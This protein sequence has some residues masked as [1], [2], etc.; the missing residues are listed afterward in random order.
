MVSG[1]TSRRRSCAARKGI[2]KYSAFLAIIHQ[3]PV[4][5]Q[6]KLIAEPWDIGEGGY[7]VGNFPV[8]WAEWNGK[9]RDT[10]RRWWKGDEWHSAAEFALPSQRQFGP[11][12]DER[13]ASVCEHQLHHRARRIHAQRSRLL[14][15]QAQRIQR[16]G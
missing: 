14:Q 8:L 2:S 15:Q 4:L 7:L 12:S 11:V 1:S 6:V 10:V 9:Y 16:R 5:S 13:Q 3:D